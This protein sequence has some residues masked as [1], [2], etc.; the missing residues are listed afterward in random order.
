MRLE[1]PASQVGLEGKTING[2]AFTLYN[3]RATWDKAGKSGASGGS[4]A[5]DLRWMVADQLGTPRMVAD[6]TGSL[7]GMRRHDYLPFGEE[8]Y[9]GAGGRTQPQGYQSGDQV[10]QQFTGYE[11][12]NETGLDYAQARYYASA[13]GRFTSVDPLMA[14]A[15]PINPQTWNRYS[16]TGNNPINLTDP[17]GMIA[18][19]YYNQQGEWIGTDGLNDGQ[20]YLVT[21]QSEA[22]RMEVLTDTGVFVS[23]DSYTSELT[24]P[25]QSIRQDIGVTAVARSNAP[26]GADTR[27]GF[28][29]DGGMVIATATGQLDIPAQPGPLGNPTR[30][31]V[32]AEINVENP[33]TPNLLVQAADPSQ[34]ET[35]YHVHPSGQVRNRDGSISSFAQPPSP[36]DLA[37]AANPN[38]IPVRLGYRIVVAAGD[39]RINGQDI[40]GQKVYFYN[41]SGVLGSMPLN[42]F[43]NLPTGRLPSG[44]I[45][46]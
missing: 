46:R 32:A 35:D 39:A 40:G 19:D 16:Y 37:R 14:S 13:Q 27:G 22:Q 34:A 29:E 38:A 44:P 9:A 18:G 10:R 26:A 6:K 42:R 17:S 33:A 1:V 12:D 2:L 23:P 36:G 43:V 25:S 30:P 4:G 8:L 7:A 31:G 28:H 15:R 5:A 24:L 3:G 11:R 41:G 21:D 45:V 20:A